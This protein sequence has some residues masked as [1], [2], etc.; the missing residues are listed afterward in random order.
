MNVFHVG[1]ITGLVRIIFNKLNKT[2]WSVTLSVV[3]FNTV[4]NFDWTLTQLIWLEIIHL[5][6]QRAGV[7]RFCHLIHI[8]TG[9]SLSFM[10]EAS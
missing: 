4:Q 2:L 9:V 3:Y 5:N 8:I 1:Y 10:V 6:W 7:A